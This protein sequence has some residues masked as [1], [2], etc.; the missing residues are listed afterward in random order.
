M[1]NTLKYML[2]AGVAMACG[3]AIADVTANFEGSTNRTT[4]AYDGYTS[5]AGNLDNG[6]SGGTWSGISTA[7]TA[8]NATVSI[9]SGADSTYFG[10]RNLVLGLSLGVNDA[11]HLSKATLNFDSAETVAGTTISFDAE[12]LGAGGAPAGMYVDL[13]DGATMVAR[14]GL[15]T[16][17]GEGRGT[18]SHY[19]VDTG[20][21]SW[22]TGTLLGAEDAVWVK[23]GANV[24]L[25]LGASNFGVSTT[26]A[27]VTDINSTG[28]AYV[29]GATTF[30]SIVFSAVD[31]KSTW[32]VDNITVIPEPATLGLIAAFGGGILFI[33]RKLMM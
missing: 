20:V 24:S 17:A 4:F 23:T 33:R 10:T 28:L 22:A 30:N 8:G 15:G 2:V 21:T 16:S 12:Q 3:S 14:I 29:N 25:T 6:T 19:I 27:L 13:Y 9:R 1:K 5:P 26:G 11:A 18:I 31:N 7:S 32:A